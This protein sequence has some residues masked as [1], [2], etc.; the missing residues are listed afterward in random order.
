MNTFCQLFNFSKSCKK[1]RK[2]GKCD[3][4]LKNDPTCED[5]IELKTTCLCNAC[6]FNRENEFNR[7]RQVRC[8][9]CRKPTYYY[10]GFLRVCHFYEL[11]LYRYQPGETYVP[12]KKCTYNSHY[13]WFCVDC[14]HKHK[15][16]HMTCQLCGDVK[17]FTYKKFEP[18]RYTEPTCHDDY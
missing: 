1:I 9:K 3:N 12:E 4:S 5:C 7:K 6:T 8:C 16:D 15:A 17:T 11:T 14:Y 2:C 18:D 13:D 10:V